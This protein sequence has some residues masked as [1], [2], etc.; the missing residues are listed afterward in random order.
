MHQKY[1][2][3]AFPTMEITTVCM[4]NRRLPLIV[5][6]PSVRFVSW[7]LHPKNSLLIQDGFVSVGGSKNAEMKTTW[8]STVR[9]SISIDRFQWKGEI[10]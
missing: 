9:S 6:R 10:Q 7:L 8:Y 1:P 4:E 3:F 2:K 5:P